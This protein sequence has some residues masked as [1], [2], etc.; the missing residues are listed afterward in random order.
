VAQFNVEHELSGDA[1]T[2]DTA[3][4]IYIRYIEM[5]NNITYDDEPQ[6]LISEIKSS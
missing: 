5:M 6:A 1:I 4:Q 2:I 3:H